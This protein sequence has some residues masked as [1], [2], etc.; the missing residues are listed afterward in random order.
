[1]FSRCFLSPGYAWLCFAA[2]LDVDI[3]TVLLHEA[4]EL[5]VDPVHVLQTCCDDNPN[6]VDLR[7]RWT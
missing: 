4:R 6:L 7:I 5:P 1:M 3:G 2:C